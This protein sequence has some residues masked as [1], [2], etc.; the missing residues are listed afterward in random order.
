MLTLLGVRARIT[1][2]GVL[3]QFALAGGRFTLLGFR[4]PY[5]Y[6]SIYPLGQL[7]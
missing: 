3:R 1:A 4:I 6:L 7:S 2:S 5:L